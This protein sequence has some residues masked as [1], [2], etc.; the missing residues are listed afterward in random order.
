MKKKTKT[1]SH[2]VIGKSMVRC[3]CGRVLDACKNSTWE[4]RARGQHSKDTSTRE[5]VVH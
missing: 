2:T 1:Y 3:A 4:G 5:M